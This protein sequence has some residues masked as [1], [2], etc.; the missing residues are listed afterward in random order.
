MSNLLTS[1]AY[2]KAS[3]DSGLSIWDSLVRLTLN[4]VRE[5]SLRD[6]S[7]ELFC[8]EFA[9]YYAINIPIHPMNT[10]IGKMKKMGVIDDVYGRWQIN[11]SKIDEVNIKTQN[12]EKFE[13]FMIELQKY[14][15]NEFNVDKDYDCVEKM[16]FGYINIYDSDLLYSIETKSMLPETAVSNAEKYMLGSFIEWIVKTDQ[17][18]L[19]ILEDIFLSNIHL[20]S[21]FF[22]EKDRR[23]KLNRV[24]VYLDTRF[25]LRLTGI[26]GKF[27][28]EEYAYLLDILISN[29]C[30]LRIFDVH[31]NEVVEIL[32]DCR[33]WLENKKNYN[34]KYA[35]R[36]LRYFVEHNYKVSDVLACQAEID[37]IMKKYKI[38]VD[39]HNY[40]TDQLNQ[41]NIDE[42]KLYSIITRLYNENNTYSENHNTEGMIWNDIKAISSVYRKRQGFNANTLQNVKAIFITNNRTLNKAVREYNESINR[43]E[44]YSECV[45][46]T[47][48]GT[49]I[50]LNT[51]YKE[52]TF[53]AKKLIADSVALTELNPKLK[54]KYLNNIKEKKEKGNFS[55]SEYYLLREY[56]GASQY[57]KNATFNDEDEYTDN[58]PEEII[59]RF[60]EETKKPLQEIIANNDEQIVEKDKELL[61]HRQRVKKQIEKID[62]TAKR[63]SLAL[64]IGLGIIINIPSFILTFQE[65]VQNAILLWGIR[66][67]SLLIGVFF[68]VDGFTRI[69]I[70]KK[71]YNY[72]K[73]DLFKKWEINN[74]E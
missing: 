34:P 74:N 65:C 33:K 70:A 67:V 41:Y 47:Y 21:I 71:L 58:L 43:S 40:E 55:D 59:E 4:V 9:D 45:T 39:T 13:N 6:V 54:E 1:L 64:L 11:F 51:A 63:F 61:T 56:S 66:I 42:N 24:F 53:Y 72:K 38:G 2:I 35:S 23:L 44:K 19:K 3:V 22:I 68:A 8:K 10:I 46:D 29:N 69:A 57:L 32:N 50:W 31:Y 17:S 52:D 5:K 60:R 62:V 73:N 49:A 26:E 15:K 27:R 25:V 12:Q 7:S 20:N 36:A 14:L 48:W 16:F 30:N 18:F 37:T 28:K